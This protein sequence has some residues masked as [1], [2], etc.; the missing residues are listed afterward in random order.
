MRHQPLAGPNLLLERQLDRVEQLL[1]GHAAAGQAALGQRLG[2]GRDA[3][4]GGEGDERVR[5]S[6]TILSTSSSSRPIVR[7]VLIAMSRT[8]GDSGP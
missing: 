7:S 1:R 4:I 5:S 8:S 2:H 6:P 3:V